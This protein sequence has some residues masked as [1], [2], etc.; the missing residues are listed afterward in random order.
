MLGHGRITVIRY[1][2]DRHAMRGTPIAVNMIV[3]GRARGDQLQ[4]GELRQHV[5][6][7]PR[8][9]EGADDLRIA[10]RLGAACVQGFGGATHNMRRLQPLAGPPLPFLGLKNGNLHSLLQERAPLDSRGCNHAKGEKARPLHAAGP[11]TAWI[12]SMVT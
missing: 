1:V 4:I 3:A 8:I 10:M 12:S 11:L 6:V 5:T 9:H 2:D 7:K